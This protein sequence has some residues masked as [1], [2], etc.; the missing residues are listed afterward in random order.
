MKNL[1]LC[2]GELFYEPTHGSDA[3]SIAES[4]IEYALDAIFC[5]SLKSL[6]CQTGNGRADYGDKIATSILGEY[7]CRKLKDGWSLWLNE[8]RL[9]HETGTLEEKMTEAQNDYKTKIMSL[10]G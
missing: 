4:K 8:R 3:I 10:F 1:S 6:E 7:S 9:P 2:L 5:D